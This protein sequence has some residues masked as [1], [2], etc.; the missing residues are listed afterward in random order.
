MYASSFVE[1]AHGCAVKV[2]GALATRR[3]GSA[4]RW[5][6]WWYALAN[7]NK[8]TG[9]V[10]GISTPS[11]PGSNLGSRAATVELILCLDHGERGVCQRCL[12]DGAVVKFS[13]CGIASKLS[14]S[15]RPA[16][17]W[18]GPHHANLSNVKFWAR[19][20]VLVE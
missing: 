9:K 13:E 18:P 14:D 19:L 5:P 2:G 16:D 3:Y 10:H 1:L 8:Q 7:R 15:Y 11:S 4:R 20:C 6:T 12:G 17:P